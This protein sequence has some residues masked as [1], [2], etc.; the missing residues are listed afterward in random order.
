MSIAFGP[1]PSRRLGRSLG[2]NNI[3][4]KYCTYS[5]IYCQVGSTDHLTTTIRTFYTPA[6]IYGAVKSKIDELK[7]KDE[8]IDY[9][10]FVSDGE[11][12]LDLNIGTTID[13]LKSFGIKI[14][15]IT[16]ASLMY[17][18]DV[19]NAL[20]SVDWVSVKID[21]ADPATWKR[22]NRPHG[23][24]KLK[25]IVDGMFEFASEYKGK[26]VTETMLVKDNNDDS[27]TLK[28]TAEMINKINPEKAYI[29]IPTRPPSEA[30]VNPPSESKINLAYQIFK[31]L[32]INAELI[33]KYEGNSF[34]FNSDM[35]NE[36]L[37]ILA[38]HPMRK[39]AVEKYLLKSGNDS[40]IIDDLIN[41]N[42][43]KEV[44]YN[45]NSFII[46]RKNFR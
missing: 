43:V 38:V 15:V 33:T 23:L 4:Q 21:S 36:L 24:L 46:N 20:R 35:E 41:K 32:N 28:K 12:T 34:T 2:I 37:S 5:C 9:L 29:L 40:R 16:N 11:P 10:T 27:V 18:E 30:F 42:K 39:D 1:I 17:I 31:A 7:S 13:K 45:N 25:Y 22:I 19:R 14:A 8:K 26:L 44:L 3:P 6:E